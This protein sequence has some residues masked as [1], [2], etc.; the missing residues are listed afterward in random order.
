MQ[1]EKYKPCPLCP[2]SRVGQNV[3]YF[4][5]DWWPTGSVVHDA[6][7]VGGDGRHWL[8]TTLGPSWSVHVECHQAIGI[9][10]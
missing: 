7:Y 3:K 8:Q 6:G 1:L 4:E 2:A 9:D 10:T 5:Y